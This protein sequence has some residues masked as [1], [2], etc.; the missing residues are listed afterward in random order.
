MGEARVLGA[1]ALTFALAALAVVL[2]ATA[3]LLIGRTAG[4][5]T[6]RVPAAIGLIVGLTSGVIQ[7][8]AVFGAVSLWSG[9][10]TLRPY[11]EAVIA[12]AEQGR[13]NDVRGALSAASASALSD[14]RAAAFGEALR[15]SCGRV[16]AVEA[17]LMELMQRSREVMQEVTPGGRAFD[18]GLTPRPVMIR[19]ERCDMLAYVVVDQVAAEQ[20]IVA[21][22]D[23]LVLLPDG[24]GAVLMENGPATSLARALG[25]AIRN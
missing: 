15:A 6:G 4:R 5:T 20:R 24:R 17:P 22:S 25:V 7:G 3:L 12:G 11:A 8:S 23:V 2:G 1:I 13:M 10:R 16:R 18:L 9:L 19:M 14:E 21:V